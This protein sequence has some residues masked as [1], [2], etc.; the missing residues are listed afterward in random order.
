MSSNK[1]K[2]PEKKNTTKKKSPIKSTLEELRSNINNSISKTTDIFTEVK[3]TDVAKD[4]Q[5]IK[6]LFNRS[7]VE[8]PITKPMEE[9]ITKPVEESVQEPVE[10]PIQEPSKKSITKRNLDNDPKYKN[11]YIGN[12]RYEQTYLF[13]DHELRFEHYSNIEKML[14]LTNN[15]DDSSIYK[16]EINNFYKPKKIS[17]KKLEKQIKEQNKKTYGRFRGDLILAL[18]S[19]IAAPKVNKTRK[20]NI[21]PQLKNKT[22]KLNIINKDINKQPIPEPTIKP[23][24]EPIEEQIQNPP[25][26]PEQDPF[27][28]E[29]ALEESFEETNQEEPIINEENL[30]TNI[31]ENS[32]KEEEIQQKI[33][34]PENLDTD[35]KEYN[36]FLFNKEKI[37]H[38]SS[39]TAEFDFLYPELNDPDFNIK[40]AKRKEFN[41]TKFDGSIYDI[42][43][44]AEK[45]CNADFE[46]LPHQLF[47]KNFLSYQTPYNCLLL[48]HM[49]GSGKTCSAIG[50][51]EEMRSY[52]KQIGLV[53]KN[54][55]ILIV[56]SPNVQNNFRLQLFDDRKLKKENGLWNLNTCIG[57]SLL[58]EIN[59][60][61]IH[62]LK[63]NQII[64]EINNLIKTYYQFVGYD[65]LANIIRS[66]TKDADLDKEPT[67]EQK[68]LEIKKIRQLFNNRLIIIDE[69]HN[70]TLAQDNK[71][72]KK[73][74]SML[75]RIARYSQNIRL[76]LLSATPVYN[77]YKEIIWLTNLMNAVDKRSS[78]KI[79]D[80]FDKEGNF[81]KE[82]TTKD[83]VKLEGGRELLKRKLTGYVSYVRGENPYTFPFRIYPDTFS[84]EN[85]FNNEA[86]NQPNNPTPEET[87][88]PSEEITGGDPP[89]PEETKTQSSEETSVPPEETRV[90]P[91]ETSVTPEET[92][93]LPEETSVT[94]LPIPITTTYPKIQMNLKPIEK[95]L[96][97]LPVY[98]NPIGEYQE[99]A[100]KFIM[101]NLRNKSFNTYNIHGE[102]REMPTFEN[103]ESFG[104]THLQQ[105]LESLNIIFPNPDFKETQSQPQKSEEGQT[106]KQEQ[107]P[108]EQSILQNIGKTLGFSGGAGD[109]IDSTSSGES[110]IEST[111]QENTEI[112]KNMT[113][114]TGLSN[115]MTYETIRE[116]YELRK[117]FE[118]KPQILEKYGRIF[119]PDK[120][121]KYSGKMGNISNII[122][123]SEGIIIIYSQYIDGGVVPL[124]LMLEE[125]GFTRYGFASHTTSLLKTPPPSEKMLDAVTMKTK[126]DF[127]KAKQAGQQH[128]GI[129]IGE[130]TQAKYVMITGDKTF[131]PN[132]LADIKYVTSKNNVNGQNVKVILISQAAAEGLDFKNI[133]QVH[134][135]SPWYNLNRIEQIIG[136]GVRNLSHCDLP[137]EK[138]NVEIYLHSTTPKNDEEPADLYLYR[139]AENKAIQIGEITR[140]MK[141]VAVDCL[142]NISQ[143]NLTVDKL[144]E[145]TANQ[146]IKIQLSSNP[147]EIDYKVGD[148]PFTDICDY[149]DN[150]NFVCSP[151]IQINDADITKNTYDTGFLRTNYSA[152]VKRIRQLFR[153]QNF[154]NREQLFNS[155]NILRKYPDE[156]IDYVL[157]IFI[158][159][160][161]IIVDKYGRSGYLINNDS[162][163][164]FQPVEITDER[165][166]LFD[167]TVPI[168]K[169]TNMLEMEIDTT[170]R[171]SKETNVEKTIDIDFS[172]K[173]DNI[174]DN[175]KQQLNVLETEKENALNKVKL[176][177]DEND[178]YVHCGRIYAILTN[179]NKH[180]VPIQSV[181]KYIIYHFLDTLTSEQRLVLVQYLYKMPDIETVK[182][183]D[184]NE[185]IIKQYFDNKIVERNNIKGIVLEVDK[186]TLLFI[187]DSETKEWNKSKPSENILF[188]SIV[189]KKYEI[190][191]ENINNFVG[192][193]HN[194]KKEGVVFKTKDM[195]D[196]RNNIGLRCSG[197][198]KNDTIKRLNK[199][200]ESG[201]FFKEGDERNIYNDRT[202]I[203]IKKIGFCVMLEI[204]MRYYNDIEMEK[205]LLVR[206]T[207]FFD[208]EKTIYNNLVNL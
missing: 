37:E 76:L 163:Y 171:S 84:P 63:R 47:V 176:I 58:N 146:K 181:N 9:P 157:S 107:P 112:I 78:I 90:P 69:V 22:I 180:N 35:S 152:I 158:D 29:E 40:I 83:G 137:F 118:Y 13:Y 169:K 142:L 4:N 114:K 93:V 135:L 38:E 65:K 182:P 54:K 201:P 208:V 124:A 31:I 145:N 27:I 154:Y 131:S 127:L 48:Y 109:S 123:N 98:L 32:E 44:Q 192:F 116:S 5:I 110:S 147:T 199:V 103:M 184:N 161:E 25:V 165:S 95:P 36:A 206:K 46:L 26:A 168:D 34:I 45:M 144:L 94:P 200:L 52:M 86:N 87:I 174:I 50:V 113:G 96:Q 139:Y 125:M 72:A 198:T 17:D 80:V 75:M 129:N 148:K 179:E 117:N 128:R 100:Y 91:E 64:S 1:K 53:Q 111:V 141:E 105:P 49:L 102:E 185:I 115:I 82:R 205:N 70:I 160:N 170:K 61:S 12:N 20:L 166:S 19:D 190:A 108:Q 164:V 130:F 175:L 23:I 42:K 85:T 62:E 122:R 3:S 15:N 10:E 155:I 104:Y 204:I 51:A 196:K 59:P 186:K 71:E 41:D 172:D 132:N 14:E 126:Q 143:T 177:E 149:K 173:Y 136:R 97:H 187:Q 18:I 7:P 66:E 159:N 120:I 119:H 151:N 156:Q 39:D 43:E 121:G 8:E 101:D 77:N 89:K 191:R 74:G 79:E 150:C 193:M 99:K 33:G 6:Y 178:W 197:S 2:G 28:E 88:G 167:R 81:V 195:S 92:S 194:F 11:T 189:Q 140:L 207:W 30:P 60:S 138:R 57:N 106:Q 203:D 56:A 73:V 24:N 188:Q 183:L 16:E 55:R 153:E 68:E 202:T 67:K 21:V 134:I 133:R 162:N